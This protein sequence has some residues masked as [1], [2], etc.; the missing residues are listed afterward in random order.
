MNMNG[1]I[2]KYEVML[3]TIDIIIGSLLGIVK[4][5]IIFIKSPTPKRL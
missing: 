1:K 4:M 2:I 3:Y 5:K